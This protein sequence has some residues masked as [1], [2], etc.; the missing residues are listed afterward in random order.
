MASEAIPASILT[1]LGD[2]NWK[3]RIIALEEMAT[4]LEEGAVD[5]VEAEIIVRALAKKGWSEKNFQVSSKIFGVFT[6]LAEK[7]PTF[8]RASIALAVGHLTEKL[9]DLKLKKPAGDT[10]FAFAEK[11]SLQFVLSQGM[12]TIETIVKPMLT[13][14]QLM[15]L[16]Q[17]RRRR[18]FWQM[19]PFG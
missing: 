4:W 19:Q 8:G 5:T 16:L 7:S 14:L 10:L 18:R 17:S 13:Y 12:K 11:T 9:G 3:T 1:G 6:F 2:A 15:T